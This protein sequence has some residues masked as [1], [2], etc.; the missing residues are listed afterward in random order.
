MM[1]SAKRLIQFDHDAEPVSMQLDSRAR[2]YRRIYAIKQAMVGA[3]Q[4]LTVSQIARYAMQYDADR[5]LPGII[6][7]EKSHVQALLKQIKAV[8]VGGHPEPR[9]ILDVA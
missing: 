2:R 5:H 3:K 8:K 7:I 1:Q 4:P 6:D 9:Y